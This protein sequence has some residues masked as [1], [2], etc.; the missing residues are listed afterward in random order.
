VSRENL[1]LVLRA[2]RAFAQVPKPNFAT[3]N[4]LFD[5]DHVFVPAM[6]DEKEGR[7]GAEGYRALREELDS[8]MPWEMKQVDGAVDLGP[9]TVL[10]VVSGSSV[11]RA[12]G[13][14]LEQRFWFLVTV[15]DG[16]IRRT[17]GY[18]DPAEAMRSSGLLD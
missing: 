15:I 1:E 5:R 13:I 8:V 9:N 6:L 11:G 14:A 17:E 18:T 12:S 2:L 3:I 10:A 16:K 7:V 4:E